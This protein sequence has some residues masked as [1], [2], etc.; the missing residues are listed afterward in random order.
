MGA[1]HKPLMLP[2]FRAV[3]T[4]IPHVCARTWST[5]AGHTA[6]F[7]SCTMGGKREGK[8]KRREMQRQPK[9]I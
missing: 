3:Y 6:N 1:M 8:G 4:N 2:L 7:D 5:P 9:D